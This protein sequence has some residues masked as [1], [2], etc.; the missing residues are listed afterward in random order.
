MRAEILTIAPEPDIRQETQNR[1]ETMLNSG[2]PEFHLPYFDYVLSE[3]GK[4]NR[5]IES[6]FG[7][8]VHW[9]YWDRPEDAICDDE[10]F[11]RAAEKLTLELCKLA[12][13]A[14]GQRVLD[15]GCGFGG[16]IAS[17]NERFNRLQLVGLNIDSRQLDRAR[18]LV[19]PLH[20]NVIEFH[21]GDACD[22]PFS[23][24]SF[25]R[26]LAVECIFHF[27]S[28]R[29]FF[30]EASRVLKPGGLLALSDFVS[31]RLFM[32]LNRF[33]TSDRFKKYNVFGQCQLEYQVKNYRALAMEVGLKSVTERNVTR[34]TLP[35]Y[36]YLA[37]M[38]T[39]PGAKGFLGRFG[40][41]FISLQRLLGV[42]GP[43]NY[44]MLSFQKP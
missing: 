1:P 35:T 26:L 16:T 2:R 44:Y 40:A 36:R 37:Q 25:D 29:A 21:Q 14:E 19:H 5:V 34:Q 10:D 24:Q 13:I 39:R 22:L 15:V 43:L 42:Y 17:L 38:L 3:L 28:R 11:G 32:P 18:Q 12:G 27:P 7:R 6:S 4:K 8:H 30:K 23:D 41:S 9:G 33:T 31:T 20:D